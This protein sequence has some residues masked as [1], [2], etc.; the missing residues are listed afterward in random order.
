MHWDSVALLTLARK[1]LAVQRKTVAPT[2]SKPTIRLHCCHRLDGCSYLVD[3][4]SAR[5]EAAPSTVPRAMLSAAAAAGVCGS[6]PDIVSVMRLTEYICCDLRRMRLVR[7]SE[8]KEAVSATCARSCSFHRWCADQVILM[9]PGC[10]GD[11]KTS[12]AGSR[13]HAHLARWFMFTRRIPGSPLHS[14]L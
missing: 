1:L 5:S 13:G 11:I 7:S 2:S 6:R 4:L 9:M 3:K 8:G 14:R 12:V 10:E